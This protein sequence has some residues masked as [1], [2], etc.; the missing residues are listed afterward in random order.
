VAVGQKTAI[1]GVGLAESGTTAG[2]TFTVTLSDTA[3][4]LAASGSGLSG[5]GTTSLTISGSLAQVNAD[6][7]TLTDTDATAGSDTIIL[8]ASDSFGNSAT[9]ASIAVTAGATPVITA[10][11]SATVGVKHAGSIPGV[12]LAEAG[13]MSSTTFTVT[14]ADTVGKLSATGTGVS[15]AGTHALTITGSL[16]QV[17][18]DLATLTDTSLTAGTEVITVGA[19]DSLGDTAAGASIAVT[20]NAAPVITAPATAEI[21]EGK[22]TAIAGVGISESGVTTGETFTVALSDTVGALSATGT[23]VKGSGSHGLVVTGSLAQVNADLATLTDTQS[24]VGAD[25]IRISASDSFGNSA[26]AASIAV[27]AAAPKALP[28]TPMGAHATAILLFNQFAAGFGADRLSPALATWAE[29]A[30]ATPTLIAAP[31][32]GPLE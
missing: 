13:A 20:V 3:G 6:L 29:P 8:G 28:N 15:G 26:T 23:G 18:A 5:S 17:N 4:R 1:A 27:S 30:R 7:A 14:L 21:T 2:E 19:A 25:T 32:R 11:A 31:P 9:S 22:A 16:T 24:T 12:S 10:P